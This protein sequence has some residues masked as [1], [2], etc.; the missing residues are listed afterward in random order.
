[1]KDEALTKERILQ[2]AEEALRRFGQAKATVLDVARA[3]GVSHGSVYRHFPSKA[4]LQDAVAERWLARVSTPLAQVAAEPGSAVQ[5]LRRWFEV[6]IRFKRKKVLDDPEMFDTYSRL[7]ADSR[8]V[9]R[10]HV[11]ALTDQLSRILADGVEAGEFDIAHPASAAKAVFAATDRFHNPVHAAE[12]SDPGI[13][14]AFEA[15]F[16]LLLRGLGATAPRQ[17]AKRGARRRG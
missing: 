12:W 16:A 5:R 14:A 2:A 10:A 15:V 3:L 7:V 9:V 13:D 8:D 6:L 1:V 4:A 11:G 17:R